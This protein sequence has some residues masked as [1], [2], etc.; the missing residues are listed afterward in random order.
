MDLIGTQFHAVLPDVLEQKTVAGSKHEARSHGTAV[1]FLKILQFAEFQPP[2]FATRVSVDAPLPDRIAFF[3][4]TFDEESG[5]SLFLQQQQKK[6]R[7]GDKLNPQSNR[8]SSSGNDKLCLVS[9]KN[10]EKTKRATDSVPRSKTK[11]QKKKQFQLK[12]K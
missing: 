5:F 7:R 8:F 2:C 3:V 10:G 4:F 12:K 9:Q 11:R 1:F 6:R